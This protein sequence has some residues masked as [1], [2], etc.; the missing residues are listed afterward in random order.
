MVMSS[1]HALPFSILNPIAQL[2]LFIWAIFTTPIAVVISL[3]YKSGSDKPESDY[4]FSRLLIIIGV[5]LD[6]LVWLD[7]SI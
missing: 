7:L 2:L 4:L 5:D 3:R 6:F 1:T